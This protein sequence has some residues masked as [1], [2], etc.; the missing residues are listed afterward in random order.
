ML[1]LFYSFFSSI[2]RIGAPSLSSTCVPE[3]EPKL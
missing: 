1:L 2:A 3:C